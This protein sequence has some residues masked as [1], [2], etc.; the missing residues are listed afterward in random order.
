MKNS[1][2]TWWALASLVWVALMVAMS[3]HDLKY[4]LDYHLHRERIEAA[5][6]AE[7][8]AYEM[9]RREAEQQVRLLLDAAK[10]YDDLQFL[11]LAAKR[12]ARAPESDYAAYMDEIAQLEQTYDKGTLRKY[13]DPDPQTAQT[14]LAEAQ[15][16]LVV[17]L[18]REPRLAAILFH[19]IFL[20]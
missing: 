9:K 12:T 19:F 16:R 5:H 6:R 10:R 20:G 2:R 15:A 11:S 4:S 8:A 7:T 14:L 3:F 17:P 13:R 1:M 18:M